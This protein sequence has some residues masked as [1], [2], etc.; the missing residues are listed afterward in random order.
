ML[1]PVLRPDHVHLW[2]TWPDQVQDPKLLRSY[3]EILDP[4]E[5]DRHGRFYFAK[6]RHQYLVAHALVRCCLS[7]YAPLAPEAWRFQSNAYG[8]PELDPTC[9][10]DLPPL[11]FN[12]SHTDGLVACA[13]TRSRDIGVDVEAT[14]RGGALLEIAERYFAPEEFADL[15]RLPLAAQVNRF[16]DYWTLKEAYIKARGMGLA[17]SLQHFSYQL[18]QQRINIRFSSAL[19]DQAAVWQFLLLALDRGYR[20]ALAVHNESK[21]PLQLGVWQ[22]IPMQDT[23]PLNWSSQLLA[24]GPIPF[25]EAEPL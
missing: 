23:Q 1:T 20:V 10:Q 13:V 25:L 18:E 24:Q 21:V 14:Q 22:T 6:H 3:L 9:G 12:L 5:R 11:R 19:Q 4:Q 8:R 17:L 2:L 16:F 15:K 7:R